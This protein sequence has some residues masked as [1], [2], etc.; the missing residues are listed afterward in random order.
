MQQSRDVASEMLN[1]IRRVTVIYNPAANRGNAGRQRD[2]LETY[3]SRA[4]RNLHDIVSWKVLETTHQGHAEELA[5]EA[6][7][8]GVQIIV[9]AGGDGTLG[10]VVNG[11]VGAD[12]KLG[13]MP[14]GTGNDFARTLGTGQTIKEAVLSIFY[15]DPVKVDIGK[16]KDRYFINVAGCGFDAII[17]NHV[18]TTQGK[19]RGRA[20]YIA[21]VYQSLRHFE[22]VDME[23]TLDGETRETKALLC[24][25]ANARNY[26]GGM[27]VAPDALVND[28]LFDVCVVSTSKWEFIKSFPRVFKGTH[29]SHPDVTMA[30]AKRVKIVTAKPMPV[31]I[32]GESFGT[33]PAEFTLIPQAITILGPERP[34][35]S[36]SEQFGYL[37]DPDRG[38]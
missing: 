37:D 19:L 5:R 31:L 3:M 10:E 17:A 36:D 18:N 15:G 24:A 4:V 2:E 9:A 12:V 21:A 22:A 7:A 30:R 25:V 32:D 23:L 11:I 8:N 34:P 33:T 35:N 29:T 6:V 28:G 38:R 1:R 26:G 27:K 13:I 16:V 20:A 14:M